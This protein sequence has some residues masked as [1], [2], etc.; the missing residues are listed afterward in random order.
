MTPA[1][2]LAVATALPVTIPLKTKTASFTHTHYVAIED[3][4]LWWKPNP[5][6]TGKTAE[7]ALVPPDGLPGPLQLVHLRVKLVVRR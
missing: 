1:L 6:T 5:E 3:G 4:K 2:V 7:W